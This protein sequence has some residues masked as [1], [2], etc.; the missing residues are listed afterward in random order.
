[1]IIR[2]YDNKALCK[3]NISRDGWKVSFICKS[4]NRSGKFKPEE[5]VSQAVIFAKTWR[6]LKHLRT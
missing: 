5:P 2:R 4:I 3:I 1:M 6:P